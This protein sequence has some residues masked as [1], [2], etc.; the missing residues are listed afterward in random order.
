M[1][2]DFSDDQRM[3]KDSVDRLIADRYQLD[4][5]RT[6]MESVNGWSDEVWR[7]CV[8]LGLTMLPFPESVGGLGLGSVELMIVGEA[9]GRGLVVEP[10]L[11]SIVLAG[12]AILHGAGDRAEE[13]LA[14][15]IAGETIAAM[16]DLADVSI[17]DGRLSG[18][19]ELVL[20][21]NSASLFV[22]PVKA[23]AYLV[24]SDAPG[25]SIRSYMIH[26]GGGAADLVLDGVVV[27]PAQHLADGCIT[28]ALE[29]GIGFL[30]AE[31]AG[32]MQAALE[33]TVEYLKVRE[34]FG[35]AIGTNQSLQHRAAEM[36]VEVEQACSAAIYAAILASEADPIER[37]KGMS[38]VKAV[39]GKSGRFVAQNAVQL[40]GGIGVSEEH[41]VSHWFRRLTA[42]GMV[43]G[44]TE[45]HV[46]R[47]VSL[48]GFTSAV[49]H[50][51]D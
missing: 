42:L 39:I 9:F 10:Y 12:T 15:V 18:T 31:A 33:T 25:L 40:H 29:A 2:F 14:P 50:L 37:A 46:K 20:G 22:I 30:A 3:L 26:G 1:N 6:Y 35:R 27:D 43:L 8:E 47:L 11:S 38:A 24:P 41:V 32:A 45:T 21:G 17:V 28:R 19:A 49:H 7:E 23:G 4:Q 34:Q 13:F 5:R 48:G 51:A 44:N 36:Q 16:A